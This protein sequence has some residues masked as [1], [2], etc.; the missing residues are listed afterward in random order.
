M[1]EN[2]EGGVHIQYC[3][4][5]GYKWKADAIAMAV[6]TISGVEAT[7]TKDPGTT[8]NL[9]VTFNGNVVHDKVGRGDA[10]MTRQ[11]MQ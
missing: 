3:G 1:A 10:D 5:W 7:F 2:T 11:N 6:K 8:G 9:K 4:G